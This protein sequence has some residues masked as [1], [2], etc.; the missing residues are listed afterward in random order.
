MDNQQAIVAPTQG[1]LVTILNAE[2]N[3]FEAETRRD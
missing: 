1:R 2:K 3:L